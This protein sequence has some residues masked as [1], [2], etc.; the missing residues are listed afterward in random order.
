MLKKFSLLSN[1]L[2]L[3][4]SGISLF[5][6]ILLMNTSG[7]ISEQE[8]KANVKDV[9]KLKGE[10]VQVQ[11]FIKE[12]TDKISEIEGNIEDIREQQESFL[13]LMEEPD[14]EEDEIVD[15]DENTDETDKEPA[16]E[17]KVEVPVNNN[18][19]KQ[20]T[21]TKKKE[22]MTVQTNYLHLRKSPGLNGEI[23]TILHTGDVVNNLDEVVF[24]DN[25]YWRKVERNNKVGWVASRYLK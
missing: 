25:Y 2:A 4:V 24:K 20:E 23:M 10:M 3:A 9:E 15:E 18:D 8:F 11:E 14:D 5:C 7:N 16:D 21:N 19:K 17:D 22:K 6:I 12:T 13:R 1:L